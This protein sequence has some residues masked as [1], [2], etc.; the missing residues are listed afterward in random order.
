MGYGCCHNGLACGVGY[1]Y[2]TSFSSVS[3]TLTLTTI[4]SNSIT[5]TITTVVQTAYTE[6]IATS[7][8]TSPAITKFTPSVTAV[9]KVD[10]TSSSSPGGLTQAQLGGI[11]GA[12]AAVVIVVGLAT[13]LILRRLNAVERDH[14]AAAAKYSGSG[15]NKKPSSRPRLS[16]SAYENISIDPLMMSEDGDDTTPGSFGVHRPSAVFSHRSGYDSA[17]SPPIP[18]PYGSPHTYDGGYQPVPISGSPYYDSSSHHRSRSDESQGGSQS[19]RGPSQVGCFDID[20]ALRDQNLR[21]GHNPRPSLQSH[22]RQTSDVSQ[23]SEGSE[24]VELDGTRHLERRN[25]LQRAFG[26]G[27]S[28]IGIRRHSAEKSSRSNS[29]GNIRRDLGAAPGMSQRLENVQESPI[30]NKGKGK[31]LPER[32]VKGPDASTT[33]QDPNMT[34]PTTLKSGNDT[35]RQEQQK[36]LGYLDD[37]RLHD[38]R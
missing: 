28:R 27:V 26:A 37:L 36:V 14:K 19:A 16:P 6:G 12:A 29:S 24:P 35:E 38:S 11:I 17:G 18:A 15:S 31:G 13:F 7:A 3:L 21:H 30:D 22:S 34:I 32:S 2:A 20:P 1:C 5:S 9:A 8:A 10:A 25:S 23:Q 4:I 33:D